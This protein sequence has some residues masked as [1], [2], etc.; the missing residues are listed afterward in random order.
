MNPFRRAEVTPLSNADVARGGALLVSGH[1]S[2][3]ALLS[4]SCTR[5]LE[6]R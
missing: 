5:P 1:S 3:Q 6:P 2:C 4:L